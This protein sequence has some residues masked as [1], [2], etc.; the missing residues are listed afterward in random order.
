MTR[1]TPE[2]RC[3]GNDQLMLSTHPQDHQQAKKF[4]ADCPALT[5]CQ[6]HTQR[7]LEDESY[8]LGVDGT[9]AGVLYVNGRVSTSGRGGGRK[10][11]TANA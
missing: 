1:E 4:C 10:P 11:V 9:W 8:G 2:R 7:C 5:W 3:I 6:R